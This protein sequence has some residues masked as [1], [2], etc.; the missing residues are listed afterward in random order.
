MG[1]LI[2]ITLLF[3][4]VFL[5]V[6]CEGEIALELDTPSNVLITDGVVTW[7]AVPEATEYVIV[8]GQVSYTVTTTTFNLNTLNLV[9]G[10][11]T[12]HIIAKAGTD[13]SLPSTTKSYVVVSANFDT[14]LSQ[15]LEMMDPSFEPDMDQTD[16]DDEREYI[17]YQNMAQL[18]NTY[19]QTAVGLNMSD[20]EVI[21]T[22]TYVQTMPERMILVEGVYDM[23]DEIDG[24]FELGMTSEDMAKMIVE[25]A[26]V[27]IEIEIEN[28]GANTLDRI[29]ELALVQAQL[30]AFTLDASAI[31]VYNELASYASPAELI[32]LDEIFEAADPDLYDVI[33]SFSSIAYDLAYYFEFH[34]PNDYLMSNNEH[35]I[36]AYNLLMEAKLDDNTALLNSIMMYGTLESLEELYQKSQDVRY[37]TEA[38]ERDEQNL[39]NLAELLAFATLEKQMVLDSVEGVI[40]Y[41]TLVYDTIPATVFATLDDAATTGEL[42]I[43]EYFLLK[44]E[45]IDVLE[46]TLPSIDDFENMYVMI[47]NVAQIMGD[48]DLTEMMDYANYFAQVD[49]AYIDLA[50]TLADDIDQSMIEDIMLITDGMVIP[51]ESYYDEEYGYWYDESDTVDF[52]KLIELV[53]YL[54]TFAQDFIEVNQ[55]KVQTLNTLMNSSEVEELFGIAAENLL[56]VLESEM[57]PEEFEIVELMVN[58]L[59]L[60]YDNLMAGI[61]SVKDTGIL[62]IEHF[63]ATEGQLFLDIYDLSTT[64]SGDFTDLVFVEDLEAVFALIVE[65]NNLLLGEVNPANV[66]TMLRA[67]RVPLKYALVSSNP[68]ITYAEFDTLFTAIVGDIATVIG[69]LSSLEQQIMNSLDTLDASALLIDGDWNLEPDDMMFGLLVLALDQAMT[70]VYEDLFF[71]TLVV[72]SDEIMK[73]PTVLDLTGMLTTDVDLMFDDLEDYYNDLFLDIHQVADYDFSALTLVQMNELLGLFERLVPPMDN[74]E[75]AIVN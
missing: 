48:V 27:G 67:I 23:T 55:V 51:G 72:I 11:Y 15:I 53:V 49:H 45:I 13:V 70:T 32:L 43:Q 16:F 8:V 18:A 12:V 35:M 37:Y 1:K 75:P 61:D 40:E 9:A 71:A 65:Y 30:D 58:E 41:V 47:F 24:F 22:F 2:R 74:P 17:N 68:D 62:M 64:G 34:N 63:L 42:T 69:N 31:A 56:T 3:L 38:I 29:A 7:D 66:E 10:T 50:L 54:G 6:S 26:L 28:I 14:L 36:V 44:N 5:L 46:T 20:A 59:V 39:L 60:D 19:V 25:L 57:D 4:T 52:P 73:N 21:E 33:W